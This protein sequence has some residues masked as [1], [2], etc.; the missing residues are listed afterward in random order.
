METFPE[1]MQ[2]FYE[3]CKRGDIPHLEELIAQGEDHWPLAAFAA[4]ETENEKLLR[5]VFE[6]T[7]LGDRKRKRFCLCPIELALLYNYDYNRMRTVLTNRRY[8]MYLISGNHD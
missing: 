1:K 4:T 7:F 6:R 5:Y 2:H 3:T 8:C